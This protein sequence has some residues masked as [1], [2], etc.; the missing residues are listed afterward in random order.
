MSSKIKLLIIFWCVY[1]IVSFS[2]L[3]SYQRFNDVLALDNE[4]F[5][6]FVTSPQKMLFN[7]IIFYSVWLHLNKREF[8]NAFQIIRYNRSCIFTIWLP[9]VVNSLIFCFG[10]YITFLFLAFIKH[11]YIDL[12]IFTNL[13]MIITFFIKTSAIYILIYTITSRYVFSLFF[14]LGETFLILI[15]YLGLGFI[16]IDLTNQIKTLL[17]PVYS[18]L[19][20]IVLLI[21]SSYRMLKKDYI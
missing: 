18:V 15:A 5:E 12:I 13:I 1:L 14:I 6:L 7:N 2:I 4:L 11:L 16:N 10:I 8:M 20:S 21:V 19:V 17:N 9:C 3:N